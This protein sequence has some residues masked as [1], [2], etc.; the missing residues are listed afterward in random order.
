M[1]SA[2][3]TSIGFA[4][5]N[6]VPTLP[7]DIPDGGFTVSAKTSEGRRVTFYF[8]PYQTGGSPRFI[9]IQH[10]DTGMTVPDGGGS[11]TPVFDMLMIA[12]KGRH[13]YD[14]RN[15]EVS[16]KPSI[17]VLLLDRTTDTA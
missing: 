3:A 16:E 9:D 10:H 15:A 17:A 5:F 1:T 12:E 8:G 4:T 6:H 7:I 13:P 14:S 2:D 11:P